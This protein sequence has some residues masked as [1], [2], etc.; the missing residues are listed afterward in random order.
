MGINLISRCSSSP[1]SVDNSNPDPS[2][3]RIIQEWNYINA[4]IILVHYPNCKNF[5]GNKLL[6]YKGISRSSEL[7][8]KLK[9]KLDPHFSSTQLCPVARFIPNHIGLALAKHLAQYL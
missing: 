1:Y 9:N 8:V 5:E 2:N 3:F 7:L 6:V 4:L